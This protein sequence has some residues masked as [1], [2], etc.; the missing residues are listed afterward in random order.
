MNQLKHFI[1]I[2]LVFTALAGVFMWSSGFSNLS[3][4]G[5]TIDIKLSATSFI[6]DNYEYEIDD[7]GC[8]IRE[9]TI[10]NGVNMGCEAWRDCTEAEAA[11]LVRFKAYIDAGNYDKPFK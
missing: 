5:S 6:I 1:T 11:E 4:S 3:I 10:V 8:R 9:C 2:K 7:F